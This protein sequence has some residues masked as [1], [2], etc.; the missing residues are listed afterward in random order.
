[1]GISKLQRQQW[2]QHQKNKEICKKIIPSP[3]NPS[4][5]KEKPTITKNNK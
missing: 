3:V 4:P 1:M 2:E 5:A